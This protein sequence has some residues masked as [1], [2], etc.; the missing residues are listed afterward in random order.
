MQR[1]DAL[2]HAWD[3]QYCNNCY[4]QM[5]AVL[6]ISPLIQ[7]GMFDSSKCYRQAKKSTFYHT[8]FESQ[9]LVVLQNSQEMIKQ[10]E[11]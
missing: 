2:F 1:N 4:L 5:T 6:H 9:A 7:L 11:S 8:C 3:L 10:I